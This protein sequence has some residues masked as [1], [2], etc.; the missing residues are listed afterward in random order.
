MDDASLKMSKNCLCL[1]SYMRGLGP[2]Y[3]TY[4]HA[5][6]SLFL[7]L[8]VRG[9]GPVYAG[10]CL[11][12]WALTRVHETSSRSSTLPIFTYFSSVSLPCAILTHLF[13]IF[14]FAYHYILFLSS[15]L[16]QNIII[17]KFC[18]NQ[19]SNVIFFFVVIISLCW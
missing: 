1:C 15:F 12:S 7:R 5:Y 9:N 11:C 14:A 4:I 8:C 17:S 16:L 10:S 13:V 2:T 19:E 3:V 18:L 6:A